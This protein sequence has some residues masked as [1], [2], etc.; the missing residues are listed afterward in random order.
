MLAWEVG[1]RSTRMAHRLMKNLKNRLDG[2]RIQL[3][4]DGHSSYPIAVRR[5]FGN[6]ID[7]ATLVKVFDADEPSISTQ[8]VIGNPDPQHI[9]TSYIESSNRSLRMGIKRF[10]RKTSAYS[11]RLKSHRYSVALYMLYHNFCWE[12]G[13]LG[14]RTP[15]QAIGLAREKYDTKW[16]VSLLDER[17]PKPNRPKTYKKS[18]AMVRKQ[19]TTRFKRA[20]TNK[21]MRAARIKSSH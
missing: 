7:Y 18:R 14:G 11:K 5:A 8:A 4:T 19:L 1:D 21:K 3:T 13:G 6:D 16:I 15:A 17:A 20:N 2:Q 9:N 10:T 12:H